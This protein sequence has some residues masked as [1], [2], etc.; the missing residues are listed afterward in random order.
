MATG[1]VQLFF[2]TI[3]SCRFV[4]PDGSEAAF[5]DGRYATSDPDKAAYLDYEISKGHPHIHRD[6]NNLECDAKMLDPMEELRAKIIKEAIE[7][8]IV[9]AATTSESSQ[10]PLKPASSADLVDVKTPEETILAGL[11]IK[12]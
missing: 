2:C 4:F 8:G 7:A 6:L 3:K 11:T 1:T 12:K 5:I 9:Q 10:E